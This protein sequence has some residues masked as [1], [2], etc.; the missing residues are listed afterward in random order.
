MRYDSLI[1]FDEAIA[2]NVVYP[3]KTSSPP[4]PPSTTLRCSEANFDTSK[5]GIKEESPNGSSRTS[6]MPGT[7]SAAIS[8][9]TISS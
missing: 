6:I 9:V 1:V 5:V 3:P 2:A 4:S 8:L 7:T